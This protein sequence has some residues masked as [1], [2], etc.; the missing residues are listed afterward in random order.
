[1]VSGVD[2]MVGGEQTATAPHK[3]PTPTRLSGTTTKGFLQL[4]IV[5]IVFAR[6]IVNLMDRNDCVTRN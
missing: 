6:T 2:L 5:S 4:L 1:M 3:H